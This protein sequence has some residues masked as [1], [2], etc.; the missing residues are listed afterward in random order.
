LIGL[1]NFGTEYV[2]NHVGTEPSGHAFNYM[3]LKDAPNEENP[4]KGIPHNPCINSGAM[5]MCSMVY[6][7]VE[8]R[9]ER[10]EKVLD[11]WKELSGG[12][13]APIGFDEETYKSESGSADRNWCLAYMMRERNS[14]P[15]CFDMIGKE[16][17]TETLELYF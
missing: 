12:P 11:C 15:P 9:Q 4:G 3:G 5:M 17:V 8:S 7:E 10:L 16:A 1:N 2:H 13:N 14:W 6:P